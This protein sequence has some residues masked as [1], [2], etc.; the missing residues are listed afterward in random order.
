MVDF[1]FCKRG[2]G[3]FRREGSN[4]QCNNQEK[5]VQTHKKRTKKKENIV[6]NKK[7]IDGAQKKTEK[8][9]DER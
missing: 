3:A 4:H 6:Q 5:G 1:Y 9:E 2:F 7:K 8:K